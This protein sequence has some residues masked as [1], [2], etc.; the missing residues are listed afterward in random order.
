MKN[1]KK[2]IVILLVTSLLLIGISIIVNANKFVQQDYYFESNSVQLQVKKDEGVG[3]Q[4]NQ[5]GDVQSSVSGG[6][7]SASVSD[8]AGGTDANTINNAGGIEKLLE[9]KEIK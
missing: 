1:T 8:I 4:Q 2:Q 3:T 7:G 5:V 6:L 9:G